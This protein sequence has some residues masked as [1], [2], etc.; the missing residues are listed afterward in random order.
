[1]PKRAFLDISRLA[2]LMAKAYLQSRGRSICSIDLGEGKRTGR[3]RR[4]LPR[5]EMVVTMF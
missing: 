2:N 1:M 5:P 3:A 4:G